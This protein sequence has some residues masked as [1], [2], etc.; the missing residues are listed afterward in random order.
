[1]L[2]DDSGPQS[3]RFALSQD[4]VNKPYII[5][6]SAG[7]IVSQGTIGEDGRTPRVKL[8]ESDELILTL[9]KTEW[10]VSPIAFSESAPESITET[11]FIDD[12]AVHD[13]YTEQLAEEINDFLPA[14]LIAK[15]VGPVEGEV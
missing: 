9:G 13:P 6:N 8:E 2:G 3:L 15:I 1:M 11:N 10:I 12:S 14:E 7:E 5:H 4:A